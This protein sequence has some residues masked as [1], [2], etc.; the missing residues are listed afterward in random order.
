ML[1]LNGVK[2]TTSHKK[3]QAYCGSDGRRGATQPRT[4]HAT[5]I[6]VLD[7]AHESV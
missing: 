1:E 6:G 2:L 5:A 4:I 7:V 3:Q